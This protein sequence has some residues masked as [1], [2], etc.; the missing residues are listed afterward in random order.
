[1]G[2]FDFLRPKP[3]RVEVLPDVIWLTKAAKYAGLA[4]E[5]PASNKQRTHGDALILVAHF[6]DCLG[7]LKT[8]LD[9]IDVGAPATALLAADLPSEFKVPPSLDESRLIDIVA[10]ER[11]PSFDLDQSIVEFA[12]GLPC[13]SRVI[14][15]LSLEDPLM[16]MFSGDGVLATLKKL[17]MK[18]DE[19]I[20]SNMVARRIRAAQRQVAK[21]IR[22]DF[23]ASSADE[24]LRLNSM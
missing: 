3:S 19:S 23:P 14:H 13:R 12:K 9:S 8:L 16:R 5:L 24:W 15:Y 11:H 1:V 10:A 4:R 7:E 21:R 6:D 20:R 17:G 22:G 18:E 2:L